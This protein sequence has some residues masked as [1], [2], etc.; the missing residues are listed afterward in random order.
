[1]AALEKELVFVHCRPCAHEWVIAFLPMDAGRFAKLAKAA[2]P[3]CGSARQV[4]FGQIPKP[5]TEGDPIAW[6]ANGDT[7][8]SS[9]VIWGVMMGRPSGNRWD[10]EPADPADFG[11]CYRLLKIMPA[12]RGRLS[13]VAARYP[14]W[15]GLVDAWDELTALYEEELPLKRA[16]KLYARMQELRRDPRDMR[17]ATERAEQ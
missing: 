10:S 17:A 1:M 8:I 5:T 12:W 13:E 3:M 15:T 6:L 7:G 9:K 2:C 4:F 11:R 14:E 16:P